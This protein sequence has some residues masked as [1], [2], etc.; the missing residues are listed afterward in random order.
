MDRAMHLMRYL[1]FFLARWEV[2]L[3]CKHIP[4]VRNSAADAMSH[5]NFPSFQRLKGR[6][7]HGIA[8]IGWEPWD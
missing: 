6:K 7:Q 5:G 4:G 3:V 8:D 2:S 1:S